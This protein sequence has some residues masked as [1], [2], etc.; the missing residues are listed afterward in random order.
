MT[1]QELWE[2]TRNTRP[3]GLILSLLLCACL[4]IGSLAGSIANEV[5][6]NQMAQLDRSAPPAEGAN[7]IALYLKDDRCYTKRYV[8]DGLLATSA[9]E[10]AVVVICDDDQILDGW[11]DNGSFGYIRTKTLTWF[12]LATQQV[13]AEHTFKGGSAPRSVKSNQKGPH[14]GSEPSASD[15]T[16][17]IQRTALTLLP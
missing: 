17:W 7:R 13:L 1:R 14:Y 10:A 16:A 2:L 12:D 9:A 6:R 5:Y 15:I 4:L 8:P 11:Y 3:I